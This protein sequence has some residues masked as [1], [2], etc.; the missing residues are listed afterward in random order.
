MLIAA[1]ILIAFFRGIPLLTVVIKSFFTNSLDNSN[2]FV[3]IGNFIGVLKDDVFWNALVNSFY[4]LLYIPFLLLLSLIISILIYDGIRYSGFYKTII[5]FPQIVSTLII[6][7]IFSGIFGLNGVVNSLISIF[8]VEPIYWLGSRISA[9]AVIIICVIYSMFGWQTLIFTGALSS[10]DPN[11]RALTLID[12][13]GILKKIQIYAHSIKTT[14]VYSIVL[15]IIYGFAG[16]FPVIFTLTK[17]GPGYNTTTIDYL[18]YIRAFKYGSD[19]SS[20]YTTAALLLVIVVA[21]VFILY[22]IVEKTRGDKP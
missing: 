12:G 14:I 5:V 8:K 22:S 6:A 20:A 10:V 19:M 2:E 21:F 13:L 16:F 7:S 11:I 9:F 15:N 3:G 1:L 18:I 17:G 4:L